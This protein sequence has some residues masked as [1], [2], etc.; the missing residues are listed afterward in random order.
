MRLL[1]NLRRRIFAYL[2]THMEKMKIKTLPLLILL[3][4]FS[5]ISAQELQPCNITSIAPPEWVDF[6]WK[7]SSL[8][9][10]KIAF[11]I[12]AEGQGFKMQMFE[13][14]IDTKSWKSYFEGSGFDLLVENN[15]FLKEKVDTIF[16]G[17]KIKDIV[18]RQLT[19]HLGTSYESYPIDFYR[20]A[21][22]PGINK[23]RPITISGSIGKDFYNNK[24]IIIDY[25]SKRIAF[26]D[27]IRP[28]WKV[29]WMNN[30]FV[31]E[32]KPIRIIKNRLT[33]R[34]V[35]VTGQD[36]FQSYELKENEYYEDMHLEYSQEIPVMANDN[37][38]VY[39]SSSVYLKNPIIINYKNNK[40][41]SI[42]YF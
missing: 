39:D 32:N 42:R 37:F 8:N 29:H 10:G 4:T 22:I 5:S 13:M 20:G 21:A 12:Q 16:D 9:S 2:R 41:G 28:T 17:N 25:I 40:L 30:Q 36:Y 14:S 27:E 19:T 24:L 26:H 15:K 31:E 34:S 23:E 11:R 33:N 18:I 7:G 6:E 38:K 3:L 35:V 1:I